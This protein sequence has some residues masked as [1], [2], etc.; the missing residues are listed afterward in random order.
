MKKLHVNIKDR[1]KIY[2]DGEANAITSY[3]DIGIFDVLPLHENFISLIKKKIII[4]DEINQRE[5]KIESG[6]LKA[7][8]DKISIYI[9]I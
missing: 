3:N 4:H 2:F 1:G 7:V 6:L 5:M 8:G 9:G